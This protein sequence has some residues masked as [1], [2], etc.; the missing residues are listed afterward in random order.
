MFTWV[1]TTEGTSLYIDGILEKVMIGTSY[2]LYFHSTAPL[3]LGGEATVNGYTSPYLNGKLSDFRIYCTALS[4]EDILAL[5]KK[6]V[7]IDNEGNL[8][9]AELREV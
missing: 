2:G 9:G 3:I 7:Y 8:Y 6:S 4:A 1:Y 5:Y